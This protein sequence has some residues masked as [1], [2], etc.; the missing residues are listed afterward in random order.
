VAVVGSSQNLVVIL[1][2]AFLW[3][4]VA[5]VVYSRV[6]SLREADS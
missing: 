1:V 6:R 4:T 3:T 5:R 2:A